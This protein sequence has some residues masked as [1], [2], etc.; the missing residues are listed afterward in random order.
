MRP[1]KAGGR[2]RAKVGLKRGKIAKLLQCV[3]PV[4]RGFRADQKAL[5]GITDRGFEQDGKGQLAQ[6]LRQCD[7]SADRA[8]HRDGLP[9]QRRHDR[10][11][12]KPLMG[13]PRRRA[14]G[15]VQA[16]QLLAVPDLAERVAAETV[17]VRFDHGQRDG[18]GER[19]VHCVAAATQH[20]EPRLRRQRL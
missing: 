1:A 4:E 9:A 13:P 6:P 19:R 18:R 14:S 7:P 15:R 20:L 5:L 8:R 16:E 12:A 17:V 3:A 11:A 2:R 10:A